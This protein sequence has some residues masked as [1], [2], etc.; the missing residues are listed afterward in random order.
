[1]KCPKCSKEMKYEQTETTDVI[2]AS[3]DC[4][5]VGSSCSARK[6]KESYFRCYGCGYIKRVDEK[7]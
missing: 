2:S 7:S 6:P 1:M 4:T 5:Y 3:G